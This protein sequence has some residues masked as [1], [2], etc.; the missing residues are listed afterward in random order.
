MTRPLRVIY[1][2]GVF[3]PLEPVGLKEHQ[4]VTIS[5]DNR[6]DEN[7][8]DLATELFGDQG[9]DLEDHPAVPVRSAPEFSA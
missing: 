9:I 3:R 8:A 1:E 7:L 6:S 4:E 2:N 5:V